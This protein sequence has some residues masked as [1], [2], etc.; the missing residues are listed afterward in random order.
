MFLE[1]VGVTF[2]KKTFKWYLYFWKSEKEVNV[3][4]ALEV[5]KI[6]LKDQVNMPNAIVIDRDTTLMNLIAKLFFTSYTLLCRYQITKNIRSRLKPTV[7]TKQIKG[8]D[9][10]K[11]K[12]SVVV[13][14]I[15][16]AWTGILNSFI[17]ELY[18]ASVTTF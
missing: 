3:T 7:G 11:V 8:E 17:E 10:K 6:L 9:R 5:C 1:T 13:E 16:D 2:T 18:V 14:E 4:W 15:T 12:S